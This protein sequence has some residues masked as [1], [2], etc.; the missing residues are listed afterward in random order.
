[1]R[2]K[3]KKIY[4]IFIVLN[5]FTIIIRN[6]LTIIIEDYFNITSKSRAQSLSSNPNFLEYIFRIIILEFIF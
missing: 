1:M 3:I 2:A 5:I 6:S 4:I